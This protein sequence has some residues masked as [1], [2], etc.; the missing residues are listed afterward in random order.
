MHYDITMALLNNTGIVYN[1]KGL[2]INIYKT[3]VYKDFNL[4]C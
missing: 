3:N 2:Y 4:I 1:N